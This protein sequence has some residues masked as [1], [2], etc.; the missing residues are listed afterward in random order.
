MQKEYYSSL[1]VYNKTMI[2]IDLNKINDWIIHM[3]MSG[4]KV[5]EAECAAHFHISNTG[6]RRKFFETTNEQFVTYVNKFLLDYQKPSESLTVSEVDIIKYDV[7]H[8]L[9][10]CLKAHKRVV[11]VNSDNYFSDFL[12][13]FIKD[14]FDCEIFEVSEVKFNKAHHQ[15]CYISFGNQKHEAID[16]YISDIDDTRSIFKPQYGQTLYTTDNLIHFINTIQ[17]K[18]NK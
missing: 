14:K 10:S 11:F 5:T 7:I 2:E 18:Y 6:F 16:F 4:Q 13:T 1:M 3:V 8:S 12:K 9:L 15:M 17:S